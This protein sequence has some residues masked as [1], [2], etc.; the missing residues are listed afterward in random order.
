LTWGAVLGSPRLPIEPSLLSAALHFWHC[1]GKPGSSK[2]STPKV[3]VNP[4]L[5]LTC[6]RRLCRLPQADELKL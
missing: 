5:R 6:G 3:R 1:P 4:S 2:Q